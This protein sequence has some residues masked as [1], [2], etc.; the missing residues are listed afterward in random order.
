MSK[1]LRQK[2]IVGAIFKK[3]GEY[4]MKKVLHI[5]NSL[6]PSGAETML[7]SAA[8]YWDK[9][10]E[11]HILATN[12]KL[13]EFA[14]ELQE[15]GYVIHHIYKLGYIKQ[16]TA[17]TK[18]IKENKFD[19]IHIHKQREAL[20]YAIDSHMGGVKNVVR[21]VHNV[22]VFH[23]LVQIRET[24]TRQIASLIGVKFVSIGNSVDENERKRFGL[25]CTLIN[26]W[27]NENKF[28]YTTQKIKKEAK[29]KLKIPEEIFCIV[30]VGNCSHVK[31]HMTILKALNNFKE[32]SELSK[33][34]YL[35]IGKGEQEQEEQIYIE[36]NDLKTK[37]RYIGF[38]DPL[39]YI[40]AADLYVMP[41][42][43]E[44]LSISALEAMATGIPC[45]MTD[46]SGLRDFSR[47]EID[48]V[49]F[50]ELDDKSIENTLAKIIRKGKR[51]NSKKQSIVMKDIY[52]IQQGTAGYQSIY[53][54]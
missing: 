53:F 9:D 15:A 54:R 44:G 25:H 4:A 11:V 21:T 49:Q 1:I 23:G 50:C 8:G 19:V 20:S 36:K 30:S 41:S 27:Y 16:H 32:S 10:L 17:V 45:L 18:F 6:L 31:N 2:F 46:V 35:H 26:N 47:N 40:Q 24:I 52:G 12:E 42:R 51:K 39:A 43:N 34:L 37:V 5:M 3:L 22:F 28:Y 48:N 33:V 38:A 29:A 14:E 13:G 7:K